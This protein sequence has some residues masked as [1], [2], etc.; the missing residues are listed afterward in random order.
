MNERR[1]LWVLH[2]YFAPPHVKMADEQVAV[3]KHSVHTLV[4]RSL[5]RSHDM[6][7]SEEGQP[8]PEDEKA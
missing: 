5:K 1:V 4:F 8:L 2:F 6:F 3:V 7:L